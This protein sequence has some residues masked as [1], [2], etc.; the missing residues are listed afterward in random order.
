[1][2]N[3][4]RLAIA[5]LVLFLAMVCFFFAFHPGGVQGVSDP[6]TMLQ[7]LMGEFENTSSPTVSPADIGQQ[8]TTGGGGGGGKVLEQ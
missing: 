1:M 7:W 3:G 2:G 8:T 4:T 6:D 5:I